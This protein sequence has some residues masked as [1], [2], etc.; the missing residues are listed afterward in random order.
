MT[1]DPTATIELMLK[2]L[3][4]QNQRILNLECALRASQSH[5]AGVIVHCPDCKAKLYLTSASNLPSDTR[6]VLVEHQ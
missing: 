4:Q 5:S 1:L 2:D 3:R 6:V